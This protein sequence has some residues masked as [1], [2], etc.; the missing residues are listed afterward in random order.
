MQ[1][2]FKASETLEKPR[3]GSTRRLEMVTKHEYE[4]CAIRNRFS[5][6]WLE[7]INNLVH[8]LC[9]TLKNNILYYDRYATNI[10]NVI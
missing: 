1:Q 2:N 10:V 9:N 8:H 6:V 4:Q 5:N 7:M 3:P